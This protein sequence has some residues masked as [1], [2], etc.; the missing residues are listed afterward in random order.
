MQHSP[1]SAI[2]PYEPATIET[3][4]QA[5]WEAARAFEVR[6]DLPREKCYYVL[7]MFP[8]PSGKLHMGHVRNYS[9]GD[10]VARYKRMRGFA[11]LHPMGWDSFGLPA[12]Q[13]AIERNAHPRK[14]TYDNLAY[15]RTQLKRMGFSY[16]WSREFAC[17][18]PGY[19][20]REQDI[21][22][23]LVEAGLVYRKS[24]LVNWS[25]GLNTVLANEQ[26]VDGKCW[27]TGMPVIQKE[28]PQWFVRITKYADELLQRTYELNQWPDAVLT[29]QRNWIGKSIGAEIDFVVDGK[30]E[31]KLT[32]FTTRPDTLF[33]VTFVSIAPEHALI[34]RI[35]PASHRAAVDAFAAETRK[36]STQDRIGDTAE[37]KGVFTGAYVINPANGEKVPVYA[38]NFV[39]ADYGT[40][41]VMAVPAHDTRDFA[42]ATKYGIPVRQVIVEDGT[43]ADELKEAF[44]GVGTMTASGQFTGS[45]SDVAKT[46]I[47]AW[48]EQSGKG[49]GTVTWRLRD[50]G[51]SRQRYWGNPIPFVYGEHSGVVPLRKQDLPVTLP[52]DVTF[53]GIGNPLVKHATWA[54]TAMDGSPLTVRTAHGSEPARRET[55]TMDT[56]MQ[57]SW[58]FARFACADAERPL[59]K[60]R[61]DHWLP[62]DLYVGGIEHAVLHLLYARFFQKALCDIGYSTVREP[63]KRL[64]CQGMVC[65][66]TTYRDQADGKK[67]YFY[68]DEVDVERDDKGRVVRAVAK[69]DGQPVV[70]GRVEK[71]SKSKRNTVDPQLL[72]DTYGADTARLFVLSNQPPELDVQWSDEGVRGSNRFLKRVWTLVQTN[73]EALVR[74]VAFA[75]DAKDV[76]GAD[77]SVV[78]KVHWAVKRAT[79]AMEKDFGFHTA[80]SACMELSN[81]LKPEALSPA[82]FKFGVVTLV[83][84]LAPM[85]P[86]ICSELWHDLGATGDITAAGWPIYDEQQ[87]QADDA[88]YPVQVNGKMRGK[89]ALPR[90]LD[91]AEL[92][93]AVRAHSDFIAIVG[94]KPIRKLIV[95]RWKI[96]N[97]VVG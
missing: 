97:V 66:E 57:S 61:V 26:V 49:R 28:L 20:A 78:R 42:F 68:P 62:V 46:A 88:D 93:A 79:D 32:A 60:R 51:I 33:G 6:D 67:Q 64:L 54:T 89:I 56:F 2:R 70:V 13:A 95:V 18:D 50:W 24:S 21:F 81:E 91:G 45:R 59:D 53:D 52:D 96:I 74:T 40:G 76:Q 43:Q 27:R 87:M 4:W 31:V 39:V 55:D 77:Q 1:E 3:T 30:P 86:H 11:V 92:E 8:Y 10:A 41:A 80:I 72:V 9:I 48:L 85:T 23:D 94:D 7:E 38:A 65:M 73:R 58:Y 14:W 63:F 35:V 5:R 90:A 83:R 84:L 75:G 69:A 36:V 37:K 25:T 12:E 44:T 17:S 82:V 71:M 19:A 22:L 15:M 34:D 29:Q 16:A 47:T